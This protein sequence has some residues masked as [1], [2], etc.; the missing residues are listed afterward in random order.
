VTVELV[1]H[2][3][4]LLERNPGLQVWGAMLAQVYVRVGDRQRGMEQFERLA[5]DDFAGVPRDM[6]WLSTLCLAAEACELL[7]DRERAGVLYELVLP[8]RARH[9][10]GGV[11]S[12]SGSAERFL[13]LLALTQG[14]LA[15]AQE[16]L[17]AALAANEKWNL[18]H[19]LP[20]TRYD[21]ARTLLAS[22]PDERAQALLRAAVPEAEALGMGP[23]AASARARLLDPVEH[24]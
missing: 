3:E 12:S 6:L 5:A 13:G 16:H 11:A 23:L 1:E 9:V 10:Q 17:Q 19:V 15:R 18:R 2:V 24:G 20:V 21:L 8:Y 14:D 4:G 22:G 7:G